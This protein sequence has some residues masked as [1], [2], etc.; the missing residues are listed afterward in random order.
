M[1]SFARRP[2]FPLRN[3]S[4]GAAAGRVLVSAA[5]EPANKRRIETAWKP[6]LC[7]NWVKNF[8]VRFFPTPAVRQSTH[9]RCDG[10]QLQSVDEQHAAEGT[11]G[12]L[13]AAVAVP[14]V[15]YFANLSMYFLINWAKQINTFPLSYSPLLDSKAVKTKC[16]WFL[17]LL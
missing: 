7:K 15:Y 16:G 8:G 1:D 4:Q 14:L 6:R 9:V 13:L 17:F 11:T 3:Q 12:T 10:H 2:D 5:P